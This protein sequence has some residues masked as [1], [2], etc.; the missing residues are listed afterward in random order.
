MADDYR[1]AEAHMSEVADYDV[2][3]RRRYVDL[4]AADLARIAEV[5]AA[6]LDH[7]DEHVEAF[8]DY[9]ARSGDAAGL[10]R[11][12]AEMDEARR[13]KR[14]HLIATVGDA[15]G[16]DYVEQRIRLGALYSEAQLDMRLFLGAFQALMR[17]IGER[18]MALFP[19]DA[20]A[21]FE[22]FASL[23]KVAVFD[24]GVITDVMIA[25]REQTILR[26]QAAILE[27]STPVLQVRDGLLIMPIIGTL[28]TE[29]ARQLTEGLLLAIRTNRAKVAVLDVTGAPTFDTHVANHLLQTVAAARLMG[30]SVIVTGLSTDV[31]QSLVTLGIDLSS[32]NAVGDLHGGI[33]LAERMLGPAEA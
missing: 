26:Q 14:A 5:K 19:D 1:F 33:E 25:D 23:M 29:R 16:R 12:Q 7:L 18:V 13:L 31:A 27:L 22:H 4:Q 6:V 9:L 32:L 28:D 24:I 3:R 20:S 2:E 10:F 21:G 30:A 8:F 11:R 15:F 17:S